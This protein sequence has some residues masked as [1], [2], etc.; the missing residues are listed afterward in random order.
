[1]AMMPRLKVWSLV[2]FLLASAG[3]AVLVCSE[4]C[5]LLIVDT[6]ATTFFWQD[7]G[8]MRTFANHCTTATVT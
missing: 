7:G 8:A 5:L 4:W 1:M 3:S 2:L 6:R